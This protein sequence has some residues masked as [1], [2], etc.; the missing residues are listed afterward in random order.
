MARIKR[1]RIKELLAGA[2]S[3]PDVTVC[4]WVRTIR[5]GKEV[6]FIELNDGSCLAS[7]QIVATSQ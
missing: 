2:T 1:I 6:V 7:L 3:Q 5:R 4:G